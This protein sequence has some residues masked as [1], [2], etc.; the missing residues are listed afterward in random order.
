M[1]KGPLVWEAL[2]YEHVEKSSDWYWAVGI[3][4]FSIA[5]ISIILGN[6]IFSIVIVVSTFAL[7]V[8]A[9]R[10]PTLVRFELTKLGLHIN[11][12]Y[13]QYNELKSFWVE[14]NSHHDGK[15]KLFFRP[16]GMT[17]PVLTI[18]IEEIDPEDVRDFL[19]D[20]L[21][22]EEHSE[23]ILHKFFQYLGF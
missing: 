11:D 18:P 23:S 8:S 13:R 20:I 16:R 6:I 4:A 3:V 5:L 21:L 9:S 15:S 14:N 12:E 1:V 10:K 7:L 2:E 22:E 19:L 17:S